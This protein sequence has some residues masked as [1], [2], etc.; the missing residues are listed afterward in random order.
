[1]LS[2]HFT[3]SQMLSIHFTRSQMLSSLYEYAAR[4]TCGTGRTYIILIL[5]FTKTQCQC[6]LVSLRAGRA[7]ERT[8]PLKKRKSRA[9]GHGR[10]GRLAAVYCLAS[11]SY[12]LLVSSD[13]DFMFYTYL[14]CKSA[15]WSFLH[16]E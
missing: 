13:S 5:Y 3:R 10:F 14:T 12:D 16:P 7:T 9:K 6:A 8:L 15:G 1:M 11:Y 4:L 2:I